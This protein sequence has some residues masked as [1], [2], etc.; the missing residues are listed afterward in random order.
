ML[1]GLQ[2]LKSERGKHNKLL[3]W[4][5]KSAVLSSQFEILALSSTGRRQFLFRLTRMFLSF[6]NFYETFIL[7]FLLRG[8]LCQELSFSLGHRRDRM[9]SQLMIQSH[10]LA[11]AFVWLDWLAFV[12]ISII[13]TA[14]C[15]I[16]NNF[17][18]LCLKT[19][20]HFYTF[21]LFLFTLIKAL[22]W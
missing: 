10:D 20:Q 11:L 9:W 8:K 4:D 12:P 22:C 14:S 17:S 19:S 3:S 7:L 13:L 2:H 1:Y 6:K 16:P 5:G 21:K 15:W 18:H